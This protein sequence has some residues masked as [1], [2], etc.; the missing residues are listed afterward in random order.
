MISERW[1]TN[2]LSLMIALACLL[3]RF[4]RSGHRLSVSLRCGH[5]AGSPEGPTLSGFAGQSTGGILEHIYL[6]SNKIKEIVW[7]L[8]KNYQGIYTKPTL[9]IRL[10]CGI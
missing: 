3:D 4:F 7:H 2:E 8:I 10:Y 9:N 5:R 1:D 6:S